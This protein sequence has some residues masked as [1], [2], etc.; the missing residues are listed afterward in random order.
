V[1]ETKSRKRFAKNVSF[2]IIIGREKTKNTQKQ[3]KKTLMTRG[4]SG[5]ERDFVFGRF[6]YY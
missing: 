3:G 2:C 4:R 1:F 5:V 6:Y